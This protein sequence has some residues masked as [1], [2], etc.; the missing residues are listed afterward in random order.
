VPSVQVAGGATNPDPTAG[1]GPQVSDAVDTGGDAFTTAGDVRLTGDP[2][3]ADPV[4]EEEGDDTTAGDA[5]ISAMDG[6]LPASA[7]APVATGAALNPAVGAGIL[8][9]AAIATSNPSEL[10]TPE[11]APG[12]SAEIDV[13]G[14][15]GPVSELEPGATRGPDIAVPDSAP[16]QSTGEI[17]TPERAPG[18]TTS[19]E[20]PISTSQLIQERPEDEQTREIDEDDILPGIGQPDQPGPSTRERQERDD[21]F[22]PGRTFPTGE[23]AVIGRSVSEEEVTEPSVTRDRASEDATPGFGSGSSPFSGVFGGVDGESD[24][25]IGTGPL[26]DIFTDSGA[27][28]AQT[29]R[30]DVQ[31]RARSVQD[32]FAPTTSG[33]ATSTPT[34]SQDATTDPTA[35]PTLGEGTR[36]GA[37]SRLGGDSGG[38]AGGFRDAVAAIGDTFDTGVAQSLEEASEDAEEKADLFAELGFGDDRGLDDPFDDDRDGPFDSLGF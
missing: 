31:T 8:A 36:G 27:D 20:L 34:L 10:D 2:T 12:S 21:L 19:G 30:S 29:P 35:N 28:A 6:D 13:P 22:A 7:S 24:S 15:A 25:D 38:V 33:L 3:D 11:R 18:S 26:G 16:S 1:D 37:Q 23:S 5:A 9:G 32:I 14:Q 4:V 17:D